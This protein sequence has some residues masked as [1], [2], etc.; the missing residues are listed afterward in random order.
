MF[1]RRNTVET[2]VTLA[3]CQFS[4]GQLSSVLCKVLSM[5]AGSYME[6]SSRRTSLKRLSKAEKAS[7][8]EVKKRRKQLKFKTATGKQKTKDREG[9][10]SARTFS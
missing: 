10:Y 9:T 2:A 8:A 4:R 3:I 6:E 5:E 7:S 1:A